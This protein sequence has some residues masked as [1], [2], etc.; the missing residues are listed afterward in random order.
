MLLVH[1]IGLRPNNKQKSYFVK[2]S[3]VARFA[4]NWA[5]DQWKAQYAEGKHPK[6][7]ELRKQ[8][9]RIKRQEFPW[10]AEVTKVAPQQAIK[11]L[12]QAFKRFFKKQGK[13]PRFKK[14][15]IHDAF[16]ADNGPAKKGENAVSIKGKR[17]QLPRIGWIRMREDLRFNGQI[18]SVVV[19]RKA[20]RWYAAISVESTELPHKRKSQGSVGVDLGIKTLATLSNGKQYAGPKANTM[21]LNLLRRTSRALSRKQKNSHH[22]KKTKN[23]LAELHARIANIRSDNLHKLTTDLV[24][25]YTLIGIEDLNVKGM[26]KNRRLSR[27]IMDQSFYECR[28]QLAY[29]SKWYGSRLVVMD[30]FYPSSKLCST[31]G[32]KNETFSLSDRRWRCRCGAEHDRD[33]NA[34]MNIERMMMST[35]S[36]TGIDACGVE[37]SGTSNYLR[38]ETMPR[39]SRNSTRGLTNFG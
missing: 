37:S 6:E 22:Y 8:L 36:S 23:K 7:K 28:R 3:G 15:G 26:I 38:C 35:V 19:S 17:I 27:H 33:I 2:A 34:A 9:N 31:C 32:E 1:K 20:S 18:L 5:L 4:Y 29:K 10:M 24:L 25:T 14:K 39:G 13:Y 16:R 30:R 12:D 11:N 21:L